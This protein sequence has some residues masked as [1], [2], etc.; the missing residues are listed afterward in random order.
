MTPADN[1]A[2]QALFGVTVQRFRSA[3]RALA[4]LW[5]ALPLA[6]AASG[7]QGLAHGLIV[8]LRDAPAHEARERAPALARSESQRWDRVLREAALASEVSGVAAD[9]QPRAVGR[10]AQLLRFDRPLTATEAARLRARLQAR[11]EVEWVVANERERL[12][13]VP[14]DP[15]FGNQ[16]WLH[17]NTGSNANAIA[18]RL[19]GVPGFQSAWA[20]STG[21]PAARVAVLDSGITA[22][23]DLVGRI[24]AGYDFV[25]A[26]EYAN[27]GNGRDSDPSDPGDW[28]SAEDVANKPALFTGCTV[29]NSSWHGTIV[30]GLIAATTNNAEGVSGIHWDGR[31]LPV[32]VA[33]KCG[34]EL[35]DVIDGMRWAAG[36]PVA[37]APANPTPARI[38]S[39]SLGG[40]A[41][42]NAAYQSAIDDVRAVGAV[43]VA[44]A[45]NEFGALTRPA[46]CNG[47]IGV[48]ALNRDGFKSNYSNFGDKVLV[49]TVGGD[50]RDGLWG[51]LLTDGGV[52]TL[53]N[54]G[55]Q[56]PGTHGYASVFGT[57]FS[58]PI[59]A[60][61]ISLMLSVNPALSVDQIH[62]GLRASARPHVTSPVIGACSALNPGRCVCSTASCG[63]GILDAEQALAYALNPLAYV[64]PV[65]QAAVIDN[66]E[67]R[68][69]AA[70]G[71]DRP[72]NPGASEPP[73]PVPTPPPATSPPAGGGGGALGWPWLLAL[74]AAAAAMRRLRR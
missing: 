27:D 54:L 19:R 22:H 32:R 55:A 66:A 23:P 12:H 64:P 6:A 31:I 68:A 44:S 26:V 17:A 45:G 52:Y 43:V 41:P 67:V 71:N 60:G 1:Q 13:Q 33:G 10:D 46:S 39:L 9:T 28:V 14:L 69:A 62:Q 8:K 30:A 15:R 5:L 65:R 70:R 49:S 20:R 21:V 57:S 24:L 58:S 34:A 61:A 42:C 47:V 38:I 7:T 16:W 11:H 48:A 2:V 72:P 51:D 36:L 4:V 35:A 40:D 59:V 18:Q 73:A 56:A 74:L 63:A 37:G 29:S 53:R 25:S 50:D 3:V